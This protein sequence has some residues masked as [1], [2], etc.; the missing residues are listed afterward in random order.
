MLVEDMWKL[1]EVI[2]MEE[3]GKHCDEVK[4]LNIIL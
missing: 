2:Q 3:Q 4:K 1:G